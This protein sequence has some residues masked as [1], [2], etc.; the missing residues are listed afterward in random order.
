VNLQQPIN[1]IKTVYGNEMNLID[2]NKLN[3]LLSSYQRLADIF[4]STVNSQKVKATY[5]RVLALP[6]VPSVKNQELQDLFE[7]LKPYVSKEKT[8]DFEDIQEE[9]RQIVPDIQQT[10]A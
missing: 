10:L 7:L 4:G 8:K 9:L 5:T 3:K 1:I 6:F 2:Q